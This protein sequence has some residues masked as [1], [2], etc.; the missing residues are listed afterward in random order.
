MTQLIASPSLSYRKPL[1]ERNFLLFPFAVYVNSAGAP[2]P[3]LLP[4]VKKKKKYFLLFLLPP[5]LLTSKLALP[6]L[7][8]KENNFF[9]TPR[10][11]GE[12]C[13]D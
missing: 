13:H 7:R 4:N 9:T 11:T 3:L 8:F 10:V 1:Y 2:P 12:L 5:P 6:A